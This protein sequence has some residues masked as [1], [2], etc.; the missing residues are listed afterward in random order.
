[1]SNKIFAAMAAIMDETKAIGKDQTNQMQKFKFR[2]I[3]Q[4][5][6]ALHPIFAKH[7]VF[8]LTQ[9]LEHAFH[10]KTTKSGGAS[11]HHFLKVK[12]EFVAD[13]GSKVESV[14]IGE[15]ADTGDKG[16]NKCLSIALK[17]ALFQALL[18]PLENDDPDAETHEFRAK[19]A[20][21]QQSKATHP[22]VDKV[23][24]Y[25]SNNK[26]HN[27]KLFAICDKNNATKD[28]DVRW[29]IAGLLEKRSVVLDGIEAHVAAIVKSGV[30]EERYNSQVGE[31]KQC[32]HA[33]IVA[34]ETRRLNN[35]EELQKVSDT[36][37]A[38]KSLIRDLPKIIKQ[39]NDDVRTYD[40]MEKA[41]KYT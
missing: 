41:G 16:I 15:A 2:G 4:V 27:D 35:K 38:N 33:Y 22:K 1:M 18:I 19:N 25:S 23:E 5:Y 10:E 8:L 6:D 11:L 7:K 9:V 28:G 32:L 29:I 34:T 26:A 40:E 39:I 13:D 24:M 14:L 36:A 20:Q 12:F 31:H 37:E 3:D 17:Y 30:L 21:Q